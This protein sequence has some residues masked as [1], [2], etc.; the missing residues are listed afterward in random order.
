MSKE[1][2]DALTNMKEQEAVQLA[3]DLIE[4]GEDPLKWPKT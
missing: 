1:L 2:V 4:G 3:K